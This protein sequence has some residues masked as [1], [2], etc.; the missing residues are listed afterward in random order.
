[1]I[2]SQKNLVDT[3][4]WGEG[5]SAVTLAI[6]PANAST[7]AC[8]NASYFP[9][10]HQFLLGLKRLGHFCALFCALLEHA[11]RLARVFGSHRFV[12][13]SE[14]AQDVTIRLGHIFGELF[15]SLRSLLVVY[16]AGDRATT[17]AT[18]TRG[19]DAV[20]CL[21]MRGIGTASSS[22]SSS[23]PI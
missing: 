15:Q 10:F 22:I 7:S 14:H 21:R 13:A 11:H 12:G 23:N 9:L 20:C 5:D 8:C 16:F 6:V 1:M 4:E 18:A 17:L 19:V 3:F 2:F